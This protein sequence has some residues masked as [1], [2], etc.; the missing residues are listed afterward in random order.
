MN[1]TRDFLTMFDKTQTF[2]ENTYFCAL[3]GKMEMYF[4]AL[5]LAHMSTFLCLEMLLYTL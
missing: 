1:E 3:N 2:V 4:S 5:C